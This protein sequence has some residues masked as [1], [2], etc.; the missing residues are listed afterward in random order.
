MKQTKTCPVCSGNIVGRSDKKFCN[1]YCRSAFHYKNK[2]PAN[3]FVAEVDKQLRLNRQII[4]HYNQKGKTFIRKEILIS[5]GFDPK[6]CTHRFYVPKEGTYY[7]CYDQGILKEAVSEAVQHP[8]EWL[9]IAW[10][11]LPL[12][13][14][15]LP[16]AK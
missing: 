7:F 12:E 16:N 10:Q 1:S 9:L 4:K 8:N 2:K 6:F 5:Q 11:E 13:N 3:N 15:E 14:K